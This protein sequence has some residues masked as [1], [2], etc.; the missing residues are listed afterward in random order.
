M[1]APSDRFLAP[2]L[3]HSELVARG[4]KWAQR[5]TSFAFAE[6]STFAGEFPDVW[7]MGGDGSLLIECKASRSDFLADAKKWFR[8]SPELGMGN[9][10]YYL[11]PPN[12]ISPAE[13][14]ESWGLLY[15]L[16][17]TIRVEVKAKP[18][19]ANLKTER[20]FLASIVRRCALRWPVDKIQEP[21]Y[22]T[23]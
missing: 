15:C 9:I 18:Q 12:M 21:L 23:V 3:T 8:R 14:P 1:T 7:G 19:E 6:L 10:R 13:L 11:C 5:R 22:A 4:L 17:K 2:Q 20:L 16:P